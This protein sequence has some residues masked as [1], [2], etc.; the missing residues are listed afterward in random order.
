MLPSKNV[1][2]VAQFKAVWKVS[3]Y[4]VFPG[5]Y[6]P[7]FALNTD[8]YSVNLRIQSECGKC[9]PVKAP[10][11]DTFH[12]VFIFQILN[13]SIN[14]KYCDAMMS[15]STQCK[16]HFWKHFLNRKSYDH[17]NWPANRFSIASVFNKIFA[18]FR[19]LSL[20]F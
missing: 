11:L 20:C 18:W 15:I 19:V 8:I 5:L 7:A 17:E 4:G 14:F 16:K 1:V 13:S 6:F 3:K 12:A 10:Y 9:G 2:F